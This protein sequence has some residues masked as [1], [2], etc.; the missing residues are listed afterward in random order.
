M[1]ER[2]EAEERER[3]KAESK[4]RVITGLGNGAKVRERGMGG[5]EEGRRGGGEEGREEHTF[6]ISKTL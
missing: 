3:G 1:G 4:R 5:G 6:N 2:G